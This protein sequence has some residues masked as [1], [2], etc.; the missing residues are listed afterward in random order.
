MQAGTTPYYDLTI[1]LKNKKKVI[2]GR[3]VRDK[4]EAEWLAITI[5]QTLGLDSTKT[6]PA[7]SA[8]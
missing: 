6:T 7:R 8:A 5:K 4:R 1:V 3:S 2:A